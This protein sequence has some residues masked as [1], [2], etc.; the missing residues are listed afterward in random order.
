MLKVENIKLS[1]FIDWDLYYSNKNRSEYIENLNLFYTFIETPMVQY[2]GICLLTKTK[3]TPYG[4]DLVAGGNGGIDITDGFSNE[5]KWFTMTNSRPFAGNNGDTIDVANMLTTDFFDINAN[6]TV[7]IAFAHIIGN[8]YN[9]LINKTIA[10][11]NFYN[12]QDV[13]VLS[14]NRQ[15]ITI[16]PNPTDNQLNIAVFKQFKDINVKIINTLGCIVIDKSD[17][18]TSE[19]KIDVSQLKKG[20]YLIKYTLNGEIF[21][22]KFIKK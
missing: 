13:D 15:K 8:N 9:D 4:F 10:T 19:L 21:T 1:Q 16:Y 20:V 18:N 5:L 3:S 7:E 6:D 14:T 2:S 11:I 17:K 12:N 22:S